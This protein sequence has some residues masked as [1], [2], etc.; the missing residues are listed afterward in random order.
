MR[1]HQPEIELLVPAVPR[2]QRRLVTLFRPLLVLPHVIV[3]A[4]FGVLALACIVAGWLSAIVLGRLPARIA[5]LLTSYL[6]YQARVASFGLLLVETFPPFPRG[7]SPYPVDVRVVPGRVSRL[8]VVLRLVLYFPAAIAMSVVELGYQVLALPFWLIAVV[9]GRLPR[10]AHETTVAA[11]RYRLRAHGYF[12]L[13]T[14]TF[15]KSL[16]EP[17][18]SRAVAPAES[19]G[20]SVPAVEA[21]EAVGAAASET[22]AADGALRLEW[23]PFSKAGRRIARSLI[24]LGAAAYVAIIVVSA[25]AGSQDS[26]S[27]RAVPGQAALGKGINAFVAG[28]RECAAEG[29]EAAVLRCQQRLEGELATIVEAFAD[30][31]KD[32][33]G[34]DA[35]RDR[36]VK[37][38]AAFADVLRRAAAAKGRADHDRIFAEIGELSGEFDTAVLELSREL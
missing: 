31:V 21:A 1:S 32:V 22:A 25:S 7:A 11:L 4:A 28:A 27:Q 17:I 20:P 2:P 14:D 18:A 16:T 29:D 23:T 10:W 38:S 8:K 33:S 9:L 12:M 13:L 5:T 24:V 36:L 34:A 6:R 26:A 15:P 19:E 35:Q 3:L 37:A 30:E